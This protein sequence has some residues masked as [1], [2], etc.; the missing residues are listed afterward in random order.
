MIVYSKTSEKCKA[1]E[2]HDDCDS[3][4]MVACALAEM[5][6]Q[7]LSVAAENAALPAAQDALIK[8]DYRNVWIDP[9]TTVTIDLEDVKK[10]IERDLC[11]ALYCPFGN[12]A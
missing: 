12:G 2:Y 5:P 9:T 10:Q 4:R 8:H 1:C 6:P 3:K 7:I 11:K